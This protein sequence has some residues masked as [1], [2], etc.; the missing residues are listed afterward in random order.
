MKSQQINLRFNGVK[1]NAK[2]S[3]RTSPGGRLLTQQGTFDRHPVSGCNTRENM[4]IATCNVRTMYQ[5]GKLEN[6]TQDA[7][8]LKVDILGLAEVRWFESGNLQCD[9][10]TLIYSGHKKKH[11]HGVGLLHSKAVSQSVMGYHA[12]SD[13][14]LLVKIHGQPFD[15][16]IIQVY[17]STTTASTEEEI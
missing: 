2:L 11:K 15:L 12:M 7:T 16:A 3:S 13:I 1:G 8:R 5:D 4:K 14:I 10:H 6:I 17:A 9:P